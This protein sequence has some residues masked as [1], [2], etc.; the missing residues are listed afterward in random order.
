MGAVDLD[1]SLNDPLLHRFHTV[2][3]FVQDPA[4]L[5][6]IHRREIISLPLDIHHDRQCTLGMP[7]LFRGHLM[8]AC[9][10]QVS[11]R[12]EAD[13]VRQCSPCTG[14]KVCNALDAGQLH[15]VAGLLLILIRLLLRRRIAGK[16]TLDH[17]LEEA[18]LCGELHTASES[19]L[20][21]LIYSVLAVLCRTGETHIDVILSHPLQKAYEP[22]INPQDI[23]ADSAVLPLELKGGPTD[24]VGEDAV[25]MM[26]QLSGAVV[27]DKKRM[28]RGRLRLICIKDRVGADRLLGT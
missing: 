8:G 20:T 27:Q 19:D 1:D 13:I 15:A 25:G 22:R 14:H 5:I 2:Q 3:L 9:H 4:R 11:P 18:V 21:D 10:R 28:F 7:A 6:R 12:P 17:E 24:R 16:K 23:C 26:L